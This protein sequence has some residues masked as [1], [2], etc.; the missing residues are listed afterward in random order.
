[1]NSV[2]L[3]FPGQ[4]S[5][6][7]GMGESLK[8]NELLCR[9]NSI[10]DYPLLEMMLNGPE[11]DLKQTA[12]TQPAILSHSLA[13]Y[14]ELIKNFPELKIERVLG[15]SVGEYAALASAGALSYEDALKS[16]HLRGKAMQ[17]AS[18]VGQGKMVAILKISRD[19]VIKAC[20]AVSTHEKK[21][22]PANFNDPKQTVISGDAD[23]CD[24]AVEWLKE[25]CPERHG[26]IPLK[27]SAPFHSSLMEPAAKVMNEHLSALTFSNLKFPYIAN[28]DAKEYSCKT[29]PETIKDNLVKQVCGSV[30]WCQS[31]ESLSPNT[32]FL[33]VGPGKVLAGLIKK[34]TP[35]AKVLSLDKIESW[36]EVKEFL[37]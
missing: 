32:L 28:I 17:E 30:Q 20:D 4:G 15:H 13:L 1:M 34:I 11:E 31:I 3:L 7:V 21:V 37:V 6:Y 8:S 5:Q 14:D 29:S 18:P 26:A 12:N 27:V 25:N 16:V 22:M 2:T 35:E 24:K 36:S 9:L 23:A 10:V 33:E 19:W